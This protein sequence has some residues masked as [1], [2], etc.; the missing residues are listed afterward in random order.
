M[1]NDVGAGIFKGEMYE[2]LVE[3]CCCRCCEWMI[4]D[5]GLRDPYLQIRLSIRGI[6]VE[7]EVSQGNESVGYEEVWD[8]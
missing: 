6:L 7:I 1:R 2:V 4:A 3:Y 5:G 8:S